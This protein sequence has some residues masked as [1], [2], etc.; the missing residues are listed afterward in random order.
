MSTPRD[1]FGSSVSVDERLQ[2]VRTMDA[3]DL[4]DLQMAIDSDGGV[5][6]SVCAAIES[7]LRGLRKNEARL[8]AAEI[9][10][11]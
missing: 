2:K 3:D 8:R 5:Q 6:D 4:R 10:S 1:I 9:E 7:R 11:E